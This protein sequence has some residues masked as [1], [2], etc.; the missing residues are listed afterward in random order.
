MSK[1][2]IGTLQS[3]LKPLEKPVRNHICLERFCS[4]A[5]TFPFDQSRDCCNI[6]R[7]LARS[8]NKLS[9]EFSRVNSMRVR[10]Q[11]LMSN[12]RNL[13]QRGV[14]I[15]RPTKIIIVWANQSCRTDCDFDPQFVKECK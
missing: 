15:S 7:P 5:I 14:S 1:W 4:F 11:I 2:I 8:F 9:I 13:M 10:G 12:I 6:W 3:S